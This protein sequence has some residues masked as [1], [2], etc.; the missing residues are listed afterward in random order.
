MDSS[1]PTKQPS[2]LSS[3]ELVLSIVFLFPLCFGIFHA[4]IFLVWYYW[5]VAWDVAI[6]LPSLLFALCAFRLGPF[7]GVPRRGKDDQVD[8][9][10]RS[11][12]ARNAIVEIGLWYLVMLALYLHLH[13]RFGFPA[14]I[15]SV[16]N[17]ILKILLLGYGTYFFVVLPLALFSEL[18]GA[19]RRFAAQ[20]VRVRYIVK[21]IVSVFLI[22]VSVDILFG[23][24]YRFV[25]VTVP[26]SFKPPM[27][28]IVDGLYFSTATLT[29]L[30]FGDIVPITSLA[31][32]LVAIE[33]LLGILLLGVFLAAAFSLPKDEL[34]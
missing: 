7:I 8:F 11:L 9:H 33:A 20:L 34:D 13:W 19:F 30:G 10:R 24:F 15:E 6:A 14:T 3:R 32:S 23:L 26:G 1:K 16:P 18:L 17:G 29:T 2:T 22:Y 25:D 21:R 4:F 27:L 12:T 31:R 28:S 5:S